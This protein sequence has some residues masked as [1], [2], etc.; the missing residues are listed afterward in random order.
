MIPARNVLSLGGRY[1]FHIGNAPTTL[2]IQAA[3]ITNDF[4]WTVY[5]EGFIFNVPRR[6]IVSLTTDWLH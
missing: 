2:R 3:S 6:L 4:A 5:G 1:N